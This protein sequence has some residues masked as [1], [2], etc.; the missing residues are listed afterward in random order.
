M[1]T[2]QSRDETGREHLDGVVVFEHGVVIELSGQ[3]DFILR[4]R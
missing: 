3:G 2:A 4:I 1:K